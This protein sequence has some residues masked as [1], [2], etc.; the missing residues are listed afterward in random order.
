MSLGER[1][2]ITVP[3][4]LAY[5]TKGFYDMYVFFINLEVQFFNGNIFLGVV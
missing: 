4:E 2:K 3:P 1:V 5:G